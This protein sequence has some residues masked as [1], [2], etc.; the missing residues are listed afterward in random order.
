[1]IKTIINF[2]SLTDEKNSE[3][4]SD[5]SENLQEPHYSDDDETVDGYYFVLRITKTIVYA[6]M[7]WMIFLDYVIHTTLAPDD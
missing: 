4:D 2:I 5:D 3:D 6:A 1:M 7:I